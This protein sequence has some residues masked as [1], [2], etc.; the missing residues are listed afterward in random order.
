MKL[1]PGALSHYVDASAY[2]RRYGAREEDVSYYVRASRRA[3]GPVLEVGCGNG[4]VSLPLARAGI[5]VTGL[6]ASR[7]MLA[8]LEQRL[9]HETPLTRSRVRLVRGDMRHVRL[10][11]RF[12]LVI[13]P[14]NVFAHLYER[15]DVELFLG[16]VKRHLL[17]G[18]RLLFDVY[19]PRFSELSGELEGYH[20]EPLTQVLHIHFDTNPP[21]V[22]S[23]RQYFPEELTALLRYNGFHRVRLRS[24][25]QDRPIDE[26]TQSILVSASPVPGS[27][28]AC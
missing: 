9:E 13:A 11:R 18:G 4:R 26:D 27:G 3:G 6:D 21:S 16:G 14:F 25:F 17:P 24:D 7:F 5:R 20:Y 1:H 8:D 22:L 19:L 28:G 15:S 12:R 23:L 2:T 10:R